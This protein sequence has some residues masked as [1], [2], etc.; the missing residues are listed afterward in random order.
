[1][2][3]CIFAPPPQPSVPIEGCS[4]VFPVHRIYCVGR[5]YAGHAR[6]MGEDPLR[7]HAEG[8]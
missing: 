4:A 1:M 8:G 6:E 3:N 2:K 5:N 7:E